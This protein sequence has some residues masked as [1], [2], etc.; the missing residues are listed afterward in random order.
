MKRASCI[1][2]QEAAETVDPVYQNMKILDKLGD[3]VELLYERPKLATYDGVPM[4]ANNF[5]IKFW[6]E[7]RA[8]IPRDGELELN[9]TIN[10]R[11]F[12]TNWLD[13]E[14]SQLFIVV[15]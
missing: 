13:N 9:V 11:P 10:I 4:T 14:T 3:E 15:L 5:P 2:R 1:V 8:Y 12:T 6:R 7:T